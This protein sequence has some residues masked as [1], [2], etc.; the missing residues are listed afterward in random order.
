MADG[1]STPHIG[2][3]N[4][5]IMKKYGVE[6]VLVGEEDMTASMRFFGERCKMVLEPT[7][8]LGEA[9]LRRLVREGKIKDGDKIGV[10]LTGG[11]IDL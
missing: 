7:G 10:L 5:R 2:E 4:I 6:M 8:C 3:Y 1:A 11:N 9:G